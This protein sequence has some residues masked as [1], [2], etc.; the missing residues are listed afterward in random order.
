MG[1]LGA[2]RSLAVV[3]GACLVLTTAAQAA[4]T[5]T[6]QVVQIRATG[7][8]GSKTIDPALR[9]LSR[10]LSRYPYRSYRRVGWRAFELQPGAQADYPLAEGGFVLQLRPGAP[11]AAGFIPLS[12]T[13]RDRKRRAILR[14]QLRIKN[15]GTSLVIK[16]LASGDGALILALTTRSR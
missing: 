2:T 11:D 6:V 1:K 15:G 5:V 10:Q 13:I 8:G 16:E 4:E 9:G 12:V 7:S 3:L 14:T